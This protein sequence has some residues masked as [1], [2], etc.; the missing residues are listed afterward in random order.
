MRLIFLTALLLLSNLSH[1]SSL[2]AGGQSLGVKLGGASIG[3]ENYTIAGVSINYFA[4][5]NLAVGAAYEY[6]FSGKPTVSK[7]TI[8]STYYIPVSAQL[9]PYV[10]LLYSHYFVNDLTDIDA[11]GYR[12]GVAYLKPPMLIS[13]G[14]RQE[15]Y[16][17]DNAIF[18]NDDATA[19][20]MIGFSF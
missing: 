4:L 18:S 12:I 9:K 11:Y 5:D 15:K 7:A 2:S 6:W 8:E 1:A 20:F 3:S 14:L 13:A 16:T 10:G 17:S 19:E